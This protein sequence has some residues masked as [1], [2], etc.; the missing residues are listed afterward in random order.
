M[1]HAVHRLLV[2]LAVLAGG[3]ASPVPPRPL[4]DPSLSAEQIVR[5]L[6]N[7]K[8]TSRGTSSDGFGLAAMKPFL[9]SI[10]L[11]CQADGGQLIALAPTGVVFNFRDVNNFS[12]ETRV[13]MP[14]KMACQSATTTLWAVEARYN[15]TTFFPSSWAE[16]IFYYATIPLNFVPGSV[17]ESTDPRS[18]TNMV[19]RTKEADE[20]RPLRERYTRELQA[21]PKVGMKVQFGIITEVRMPLVQVQ[22]DATGRRLKG[23]EQEWVQSTTLSAGENCPR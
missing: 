16:E 6:S 10:E 8:L 4:L 23:R 12:R 1:R 9:R 18:R 17:F 5:T 20:C 15:D 2:V 11:R 21:E 3:C 22:Y 7:R 14:Q 19:A 13:F